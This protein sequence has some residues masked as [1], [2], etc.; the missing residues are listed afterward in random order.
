MKKKSSLPPLD[1][2]SGS[3]D[4]LFCGLCLYWAF[5][6]VNQEPPPQKGF[7]ISRLG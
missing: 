5:Q 6:S 4:V 7:E 1:K 2:S 3:F